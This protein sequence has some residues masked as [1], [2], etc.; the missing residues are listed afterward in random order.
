MTED[1][2]AP[3]GQDGL[4]GRLAAG[5]AGKGVTLAVSVA[6]QFLLV[7]VFLLFWGAELYGDWL[8]LLAAAGFLVLLDLGLQ[9]YYANAL[10]MSLARGDEAGFTRLLHQAFGAYGVILAVAVPAV[11][12]AALLAP[13]GALLNLGAGAA[14]GARAVLLLLAL[15]M[16]ITLPFGALVAIYRA[17]GRFA[18]AIMVGNAA[19]LGLVGAVAA[20]LW[21]G[22]GIIGVA[23]VF[24]VVPTVCW[25]AVIAHQKRLFP[26]L[27]FG[28]ALPGG[29]A[30]RDAAGV[31][32]L[33]ALVPL[34]M[35]LTVH[36]TVILIAALGVAGGALA[37]YTTLRTLAGVAR[38][39]SDQITQVTGVEMARQF[40]QGDRAALTRLYDFTVR[41]TGALSGALAGLIAVIGAPF[42]GIWTLGR[43]EFD[44]GVFWPLL[45]AG[46][47]SGPSLAAASVLL[48]I[49]RPRGMA[50]SHLAAG[51]AVVAVAA[52]LIPHFGAAGA[53]WGVFAA[54][55]GILSIALPVS[56]ARV[57]GGSAPGRIA[58]GHGCAATAFAVSFALAW[59]AAAILGDDALWRLA[60]IGLTWSALVAPPLFYVLFNAGQRR[61]ILDRVRGKTD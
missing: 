32:A 59:G 38:M 48:C 21:T 25:A 3:H 55:A 5:A 54:E 20:A 22:G 2:R 18:T 14:P 42:L 37:G 23:A 30:L 1:G 41:L 49:N 24:L 27:R 7:P 17:Q 15:H 53:A 11:F 4:H 29:V 52:A 9:T 33:Y 50:L 57:L 6:E 35:A 13:W 28:I 26:A 60:A 10:Q 61:W 58:V 45:A 39:V 34:A 44:A 16:L 46:A 8:A 19:K 47:L 36:G 40:A 31:A 12:I 51:I 56:A 43:I